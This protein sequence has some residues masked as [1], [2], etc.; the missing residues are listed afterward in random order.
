MFYFSTHSKPVGWLMPLF[1]EHLRPPMLLIC[2]WMNWYWNEPLLTIRQVLNIG[3]S[4]WF[5]VHGCFVLCFLFFHLGCL[6]ICNWDKNQPG[7]SVHWAVFSALS[8]AVWDVWL[9]SQHNQ[10][11]TKGEK[12]CFNVMY[13]KETD[14]KGLFAL[15]YMQCIPPMAICYLI[16]AVSK[17]ILWLKQ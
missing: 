14:I 3:S 1:F 16:V 17:C 10:K 9:C 2:L 11:W 4:D 8:S 13:Q 15:V 6:F 12:G 5:I 7:V